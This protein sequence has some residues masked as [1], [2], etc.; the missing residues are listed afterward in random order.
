MIFKEQSLPNVITVASY[1]NVTYDLYTL[2]HSI[3]EQNYPGVLI[4]ALRMVCILNPL[5]AL[6]TY[7]DMS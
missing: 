6:L 4:L 2:S 5:S 3:I 7:P 1:L